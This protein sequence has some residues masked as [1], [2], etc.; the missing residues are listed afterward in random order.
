MPESDIPKF[1]PGTYI[2]DGHTLLW[3]IERTGVDTLM[4]ENVKSGAEIEVGDADL[5]GY[6]LVRR[7]DDDE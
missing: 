2:A 4:V 3:V 1:L 6:S 5:I 7:S